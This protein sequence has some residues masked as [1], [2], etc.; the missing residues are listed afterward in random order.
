MDQGLNS[1]TVKKFPEAKGIQY[2]FEGQR[3]VVL[4][5][6]G[7]RSNLIGSTMPTKTNNDQKQVYWPGNFCS[8]FIHN[9]RDT[10]YS[11]NGIPP[12]S[13]QLE[14]VLAWIVLTPTYISFKK[15]RF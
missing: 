11:W 12:N 9:Q 7:T 10:F 6:E 13:K 5:K 4:P 1:T 15:L 14:T 3:F 2:K 8:Q